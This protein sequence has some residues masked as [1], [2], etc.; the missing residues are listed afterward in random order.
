MDEALVK[1]SLEVLAD[2]IRSEHCTVILVTHE[3]EKIVKILRE[4]ASQSERQMTINQLAL[5]RVETKTKE[6]LE[7]NIKL[8]HTYESLSTEA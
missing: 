2:I 6:S 4:H 1:R 3:Y 8:E 7:T 5:S